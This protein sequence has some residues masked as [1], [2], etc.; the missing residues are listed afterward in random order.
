MTSLSKGGRRN[1]YRLSRWDIPAADY[2]GI[3][4]LGDDRYA[5]VSDAEMRAGFSVWKIVFDSL[6]CKIKSVE[7]E[8]FRGVEYPIQRDQEGIAYSPFSHTV[9]ICGEADQRVLEHN[10]DGTLTGREL[11]VPESMSVA[12]IVPNHGFESLCYSSASRGFWT[13]TESALREDP[14]GYLRMM[15]F[16]ENLQ[17]RSECPYHLSAPRAKSAG[18]DYYHGVSAMAALPDGR[19]LVLEREA[20][21]ASRYMG[22]TCWCSLWLFDPSSGNKSQ[23]AEWVTGMTLFS[24]RFSNYEGLCLGPVMQDGRQSV[25]LLCDAQSGYGRAF[26]HLRDR[27]KVLLLDL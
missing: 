8:G 18:R 20:F 23:L 6:E 15:C 24:S 2:S 13:V 1:V 19:L 5:V 21:I 27:I 11:P 22:S 26:W 25:L 3:T 4:P 9:F 7:S 16:D 14:V 17:V 12:H 10:M